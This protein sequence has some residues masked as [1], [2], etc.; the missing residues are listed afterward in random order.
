MVYETFKKKLIS[1]F[2]TRRDML[3]IN[4]SRK[5]PESLFGVRDE[6]D[7][8]YMRI[9]T[10][11]ETIILQ[12]VEDLVAE[13]CKRK[14]IYNFKNSDARSYFDMEIEIKGV[15]KYVD[16]K[17][18]PNVFNSSKIYELAH[19]IKSAEQPILTVFLIKDSI[20]SRESVAR[21]T[22]KM[23]ELGCTGFESML[24]E[25]FLEDLCGTDEKVAFREVMADFKSEMHKAIGYQITELCS[26]YNLGRLKEQLEKDLVDFDY[27]AIREKRQREMLSEDQSECVLRNAS[28]NVIK[29]TFLGNER[30][31]ILLGSSDFAVSFVT[32]EWLYKKYFSLDELDNT[33]IVAGYLKSIEQ[34]LW[35]IIL[36]IGKGRMLRGTVISETTAEDIDK[37]LGSLQY[38]LSNWSN[39]DLFQNCFGTSKHFVMNY[40][41][42]QIS[43]WRKQYRNGFFHKH[44]LKEKERIEAIREETYFLYLLVLGSIKLTQLEVNR[45]SQ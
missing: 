12:S 1:D 45:L 21:I 39:D 5:E 14:G 41:R 10:A 43:D 25:D 13:L 29:N 28:F 23:V 42:T 36:M 2:E 16:F 40:L 6:N 4:E 27:D 19:V 11:F 31:K 22:N 15:R 35:D 3:V 32:S 26:P 24:F 38:F 34:L 17:S 18:R 7:R 9:L 8:L 20:E 37:T 30:Y 44:N 33:F